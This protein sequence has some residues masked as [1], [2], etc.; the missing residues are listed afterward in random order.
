MHTVQVQIPVA[1]LLVRERK[2]SEEFACLWS[3]L[4]LLPKAWSV[5]NGSKNTVYSS[6]TLICLCFY[7]PSEF[8][9][10]VGDYLDGK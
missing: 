7:W 10:K 3:L 4:V 8:K 2:G 9:K 1:M 5:K 6:M